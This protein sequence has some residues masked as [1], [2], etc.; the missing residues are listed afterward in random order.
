MSRS[1]HNPHGIKP[2]NLADIW[3]DLSQGIHHIYGRQSMPKKRYMEL[4]TYPVKLVNEGGGEEGG[5]EGGR[6][7][8]GKS[9]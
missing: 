2:V 4:Y 9:D 7:K 1:P 3:E 8:R 6:T 5:R